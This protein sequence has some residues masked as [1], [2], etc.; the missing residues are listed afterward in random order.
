MY[1]K[2]T[3]TV[4]L[5]VG[6]SINVLQEGI[7]GLPYARSE[8]ELL[9]KATMNERRLEMSSHILYIGVEGVDS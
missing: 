5:T 1:C 7:Y 3:C 8:S 9:A 2:C 6:E 4:A